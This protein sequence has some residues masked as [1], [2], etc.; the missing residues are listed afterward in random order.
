[1]SLSTG[2]RLGPYEIVAPIGAGGMGE[3]YEASD[4]RLGR[5]VA[6]KVLPESLAGSPERLARFEREARTVSQLSHPHVCTLHDVGEEE[7]IHFLVLEHCAGETLAAR[8]ERG[9]LPLPEVLRHGAQIGE[10]LD[11]AHRHGVVHR[12]LKPANVML[13][14]SGVKLLDFGLARLAIGETP[15]A[16]DLPTLTFGAGRPL[17]DAG[18]LLG[19][20][21][22]MAPEQ[23]E[24]GA[25]DARSDIFALGAVLYEMTAGR[26][27]FAGKSA[28][29]VM[30]AVLKE[31]PEPLSKAQPLAPPAL[32]HV[33]S[34]CL[35]K[36]PEERWQS[37]K[38]VAVELRWIAEAGSQAGVAAPLAKRR[39]SR[40]RVAW[41]LAALAGAALL[42]LA[43]LLWTRAGT[44]PPRLVQAE[45]AQPPG[46]EL[47]V[48][49]GLALSPDGSHLAVTL[50][51]PAASGLGSLWLRPLDATSGRPLPGTEGGGLPFWSPDGRHLGFFAD[52]QLERIAV[53]GGPAQTLAAA[54]SPR[55]GAWGED[56][57]IVF[58]GS[59]REGLS[60]VP[61]AGGEPAEL[62]RL[63]A[64][65]GEIGHRWPHFLPGGRT[66][67]FL[68]QRAE[69]GTPR[70]ES[71]IE[72]L[73]LAT[74]KRTSL[75]RA[76][77]SMA[78]SPTGHLLFWRDGTLLA[79]PFD[80]EE[81]ELKG[82]PE[83][84]LAGVDY[85]F[86]ERAS[87]SISRGGTLVY[88]PSRTSGG[89]SQLAWFDRA[90]ERL[91]DIGA[92]QELDGVVLSHAGDRIAFTSDG[93][94]WVRDLGLGAL[95]RLTFHRA[96]DFSPTWS[97]DDRWIVFASLRDRVK[98]GGFYRKPASGAGEPELLLEFP[99]DAVPTD[100]S[101]GGDRILFE[102][103][104]AETEMDLGVFTLANGTT[105]YLLRTPAAEVHG[106]FSP[107][108]RWIAFVA[109]Q[110]TSLPEVYVIGAAGSGGRWQI[111]R[112]GGI[113]PQWS[114]GGREIF[115]LQPP[116]RLMA[117]EV[118]T[119]DGFRHG[120]PRTLFEYPEGSLRGA[121]FGVH[122]DGDRFLLQLATEAQK[123]A[124]L[125]L[126]LNWP[127]LLGR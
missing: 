4:T 62:T 10:A 14:R 80:A 61:A 11:A 100:W 123:A 94:V 30:A 20:Y 96:P 38:D 120:S 60:I 9:P 81:L 106:Q 104:H 117:V 16:G 83:P 65:R 3:V 67:L 99:D 52:G 32:D 72:A 63:D 29:S 27:A 59:F 12:D 19:T 5:T 35:A 102:E 43:I 6:I 2:R 75:V 8:L 40:E 98:G 84:L 107:D 111:S 108:G 70:D 82:D 54:P 31:E 103:L 33:V 51:D 34:R 64:E 95:T 116:N 93:D 37:A 127:E 113:G 109:D 112:E 90:G 7:G 73:E 56:G 55:G 114:P 23:V 46:V 28:A 85:S 39:K 22:Y 58:N 44:E 71:T 50:H 1:M 78:Y 110:G 118:S 79:Q 105:E 15:A 26:R 91:E 25:A 17:T 121:Q 18:T 92:P 97:P 86:Q 49:W 47:D 101:P 89:P 122:P 69:G 24:G 41:M 68:V 76:N 124:P 57:S 125:R 21:P 77:S 74:G 126:V 45:I 13:T 36:D 66:L 48:H 87:F 53:A 119:E 115:F 42:A 88:Q